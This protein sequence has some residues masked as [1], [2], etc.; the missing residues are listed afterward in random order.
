[1][2]LEKELSQDEH[3]LEG[4]G[5][6]KEGFELLYKM[7]EEAAMFLLGFVLAGIRKSGNRLIKLRREEEDLRGNGTPKA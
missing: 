2:T 3:F 7:N 5:L 6:I 4:L 1:M